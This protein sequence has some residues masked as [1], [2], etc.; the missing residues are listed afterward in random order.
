M[1]LLAANK[2]STNAMRQ[3]SQHRVQAGSANAPQFMQDADH[4]AWDSLGDTSRATSAA[5]EKRKPRD[6]S[7]LHTFQVTGGRD[8]IH[9]LKSLWQ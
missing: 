2:G 5:V 4:Q 3:H 7:G 9:G 6:D 1:P 8:R